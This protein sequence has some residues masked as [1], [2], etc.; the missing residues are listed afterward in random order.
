MTSHYVDISGASRLPK[1]TKQKSDELKAEI[2]RLRKALKNLLTLK[3]NYGH[4]GGE[5]YQDKID[6]AWDEARAALGEGK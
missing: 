1:K 2:E 3:D 5:I 4:F 6:R